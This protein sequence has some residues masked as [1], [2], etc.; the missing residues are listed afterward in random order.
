MTTKLAGWAAGHGHLT[1]ICLSNGF[2]GKTIPVVAKFGCGRNEFEGYL[3]NV[4]L[5]LAQQVFVPTRPS[6]L[7]GS[8]PTQRTNGGKARASQIALSRSFYGISIRGMAVST[9]TPSRSNSNRPR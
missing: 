4:G 5:V 1:K 3:G 8:S 7:A 6:S 9:T 2:G